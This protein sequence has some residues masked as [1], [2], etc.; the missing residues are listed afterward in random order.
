MVGKPFAEVKV[1]YVDRLPIIIDTNTTPYVDLVNDIIKENQEVDNQIDKF[2]KFLTQIYNPKQ[3]SNKLKV[4]HHLEFSE[5]VKELKKQKVKLTDTQ[6]F[7]LM[8]LFDKQKD[9]ITASLKKVVEL[10][11]KLNKMV[12]KLYK[13]TPEEIELIEQLQL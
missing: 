7:E 3:I 8:E 6:K 12:Y 10:E 9:M 1:I 11:E 4:F 2:I 5:F 13:L